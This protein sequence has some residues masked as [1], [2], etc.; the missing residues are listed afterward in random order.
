MKR[1]LDVTPKKTE[2]LSRGLWAKEWHD[3]VYILEGMGE[4][5][6]TSLKTNRKLLQLKDGGLK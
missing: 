3:L 1:I 2:G 5:K 6:E 4:S